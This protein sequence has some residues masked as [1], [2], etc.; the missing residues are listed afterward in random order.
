[1]LFSCNFIFAHN[2]HTC[3]TYWSCL[4][5]LGSDPAGASLLQAM[6]PRHWQRLSG[7]TGH[8]FEVESEN[9][10]LRNIMQA[11]LLKNKE[12]IE[13]MRT[14]G[15]VSCFLKSRSVAYKSPSHIFTI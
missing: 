5:V 9:F 12:D 15:T 6:L 1:M 3:W 10:A 4:V 7:V 8:T 13:V 14:L 2:L 11:P